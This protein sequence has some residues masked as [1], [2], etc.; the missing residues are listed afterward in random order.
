MTCVFIRRGSLDTQRDTR[1]TGAERKD[2]MEEVWE[3]VAGRQLSA[4]QRE[5]SRETPNLLTPGL[6]A[7]RAVR[8]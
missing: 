3:R 6:L 5:R 7:S 4:S 2:H 8:K 1:D